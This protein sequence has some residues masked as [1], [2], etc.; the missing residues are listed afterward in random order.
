M[1]I[2]PIYHGQGLGN[3]LANYVTTRCLALDKGYDFR[4]AFPLRFKG[5]FFKDL[6][7]PEA[8]G[9]RVDVEG[10]TPS[11]LPEGYKYYREKDS[12]QY[13]DF[14]LDIPD[15]YVIHGNLQGERYFERHKDE[16]REWLKVEPMDMPD[17]ICVINF[18][19][20]EYS[21][22]RDFFL[23]QSYWDNAIVNMLEINSDMKFEV[24]TDD[25]ETAQ[26]FFPDFHCIHDIELNWRSI[27]YAK[28]LI[29]SNSSFAWFPA[30][31]NEDV[32]FTIA[33][34][35][36]GRYNLDYWHLEQNKTKSFNYQNKE[37]E[38]LLL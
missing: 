25:P 30:W 27:R 17:N 6:I 4:V 3:Q 35:H 12:G 28:Y 38:L 9:I 24:H 5:F 13:D 15:N 20:G 11:Q 26:R 16:I 7:L 22:V 1:L 2:T 37:G 21:G 33:P 36:W 19:G 8:K 14:I 31:L 18:R 23:P 32:K 34:L 29:I 10:Q